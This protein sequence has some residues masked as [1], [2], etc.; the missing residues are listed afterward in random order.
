MS[1]LPFGIDIAADQN[2][3]RDGQYTGRLR[4][5]EW[6]I[7]LAML[8]SHPEPATR[9]VLKVAI[10]PQ[11]VNRDR[12]SEG[13]FSAAVSDTRAKLA[14]IGIGVVRVGDDHILVDHTVE[15]EEVTAPAPP[16]RDDVV[17]VAMGEAL[18]SLPRLRWLERALP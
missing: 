1:D 9:E 3:C 8:R 5:A 14:R 15:E 10:W 18:I 13:A 6:V 11:K 2:F 12:W 7:A 4:R 16:Q 17:T